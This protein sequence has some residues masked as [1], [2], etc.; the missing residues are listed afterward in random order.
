MR[1]HFLGWLK[2]KSSQSI[3]D[4]KN[5]G[6]RP[7]ML[8]ECWGV[9]PGNICSLR[10]RMCSPVK[11]SRIRADPIATAWSDK[12][13]LNRTQRVNLDEYRRRAWWSDT[14]TVSLLNKLLPS[15]NKKILVAGGEPFNT[16][17]FHSLLR[18]LYSRSDR[19]SITLQLFTNGSQLIPEL[20]KL[21]A[22]NNT[23]VNISI[24]AV[25]ELNNY[26]REGSDWSTVEHNAEIISK[27]QRVSTTISPTFQVYNM[28]YITPLVQWVINHGYN[29]NFGTLINPYFLD[30]TKA[31]HTLINESLLDL[32]QAIEVLEGTSHYSTAKRGLHGALN[33]L[34]S[35]LKIEENHNIF[36]RFREFNGE[37]DKSRS[38]KL[39]DVAPRLDFHYRPLPLQSNSSLPIATQRHVLD[40]ISADDSTLRD[41][42]TRLEAE[43][44]RLKE[45][46]GDAELR[47]SLANRSV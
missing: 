10:C 4:L 7:A 32:N 45:L 28:L 33:R 18:E 2:T 3:R 23:L 43:N 5:S 46:L 9:H 38:Q 22:F 13:E 31:P 11:S 41:R 30:P 27:T 20:D 6:D 37:L 42:I 40:T 21:S 29:L 15:G 39:A 8:P 14:S 19:E 26:I 35:A 47:V 36:A 34:K 24:E 25:G 16:P 12:N 1:Q 44:R 17:W